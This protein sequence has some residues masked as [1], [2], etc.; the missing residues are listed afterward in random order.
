MAWHPRL[1]SDP[2]HVWL[3]Q[4]LRSAAGVIFREK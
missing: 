2:P 3:R 4:A 1:N